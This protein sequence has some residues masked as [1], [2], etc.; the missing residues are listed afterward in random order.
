MGGGGR[1]LVKGNQ[2]ATRGKEK[3]FDLGR[4]RTH[5]LQIRST[6]TVP[7]E[8]RCRTEKVGGDLGGLSLSV[9]F[10]VCSSVGT[11]QYGSCYWNTFFS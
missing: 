11:K 7:T 1:A 2:G 3:S 4:N 8:L 5:D 9:A 10:S 6:I